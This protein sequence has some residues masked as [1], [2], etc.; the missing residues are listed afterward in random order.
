MN[1][2][3][4]LLDAVIK[5]E[6]DY[7]NHPADRGGPTRWGITEKT[8]RAHG[9][10]GDM[11]QLSKDTARMIYRN[12]YF[13]APGFDAV[14]RRSEVLAEELTDT[15]IN[16]GPAA[17]IK[18][19]QQ[20]LNAFNN[21]GKHYADIAEDGKLGQATLASLDAFLTHRGREGET[22]LFTAVNCLQGSRYIELCRKD[23]NQEAFAYGWIAHRIV[24]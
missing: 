22:V 7:I 8:A 12:T 2:L 24:I 23:P 11:R 17:A 16:M 9:Y 6:G 10:A 15:G 3:R 5:R 20:A 4:P 1:F 14:Q 13:L 18:F 21:G 19:L